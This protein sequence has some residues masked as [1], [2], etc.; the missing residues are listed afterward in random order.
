MRITK[1]HFV[2][3]KFNMLILAVLILLSS[4]LPSFLEPP[5]TKYEQL[6]ELQARKGQEKLKEYE[7][8]AKFSP[9][10]TEALLH[11][12]SSCKTMSDH[13][14]SI[15]ALSF[16]NCH[17]ER[18]GRETYPC[19]DGRSLRECTSRDTMGDSAFQIYTE[20]FTHASHLCYFIQSQLWREKTEGTINSLTQTSTQVCV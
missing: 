4:V 15:L 11:L 3:L 20:F 17:F 7:S 1:L 10:W 6:D 16:A 2:I 19:P 12:E 14:Q 13:S 8:L 5:S 9:C 18:S